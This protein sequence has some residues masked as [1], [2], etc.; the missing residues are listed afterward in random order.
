MRNLVLFFGLQLLATVALASDELPTDKEQEVVT[1]EFLISSMKEES[2][3][4]ESLKDKTS[5]LPSAVSSPKS[6]N[7]LSQ[8][9]RK[10]T[11]ATTVER[12][13]LLEDLANEVDTLKNKLVI[14]KTSLLATESPRKVKVTGSKTIFNYSDSSIYEVVSA[15]DHVTDVQLKPGEE[16][17]TTPTAG[18]TVR[19]SLGVM[20]SG[21]SPNQVTHLIIKPLDDDIETN[22][23]VATDQHVYQLRL[24][25][26]DYHMPVVSWNYPEDFDSKV[27]EAIKR[28]EIQEPIVSP[29]ALNFEYRIEGNKCRFKP[30]RVFD[31]G[32][33]TFI[34]MPKEMRATDAPALFLIEEG[35]EPLLVNYRVKG[36]YYVVDRLFDQAELRVGPEKRVLIERIGVRN[37]FERTFF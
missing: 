21:L 28:N 24:K 1:P 22:L 7:D 5:K 27:K 20:K 16:L 11:N 18:D 29:E 10:L 19:W 33:K 34:Q 4:Y 6:S 15:P 17:T 14:Q 2:K 8:M 26:A 9:I 13:T 23:V 35:E 3:E 36:D 32:K 31:D 12:G 37:W 25:S 30:Q